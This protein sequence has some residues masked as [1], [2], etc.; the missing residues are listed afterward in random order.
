MS[1]GEGK[2]PE[3]KFVRRRKATRAELLRL[4]IER[5]PLKGYSSTTI[6]DLVRESGY[7]RGAFYFHFTGKEEFFLEVLRARIDLRDEWWTVVRDPKVTDT[8]S[9]ILAG[10]GRLREIEDDDVWPL[11]VVDFFQTIREQGEY[12][13]QLRELYTQWIAELA[14]FV[15]EIQGRGFARLDLDPETLAAEI[16]ATA[17]GH[18]MHH[19]LYETPSELLVDALLRVI[20]P[21]PAV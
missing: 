13:E 18:A 2:N 16:L 8:L 19:A 1:A 4:G 5:F 7:T 9:A 11:L 20:A 21:A 17:E 10:L 6:D 15:R 3:N 14:I 12:L